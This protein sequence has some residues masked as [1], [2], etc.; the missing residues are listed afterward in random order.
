MRVVTRIRALQGHDVLLA[1]ARV[2][3]FVDVSTLDFVEQTF[4]GCRQNWTEYLKSSFSL[5]LG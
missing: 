4:H 5:E 1:D 2:H 3:P